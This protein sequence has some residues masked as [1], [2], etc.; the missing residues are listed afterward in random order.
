MSLYFVAEAIKCYHPGRPRNWMSRFGGLYK[1][2]RDDCDINVVCF[3]DGFEFEPKRY[4][5]IYRECQE[6]INNL[7]KNNIRYDGIPFHRV[8]DGAR[9]MKD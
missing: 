2:I 8:D 3:V 7:K 4:L 1:T 9:I 6:K 5:E